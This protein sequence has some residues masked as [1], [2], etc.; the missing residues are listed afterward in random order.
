MRELPGVRKCAHQHTHKPLHTHTHT[1]TPHTLLTVPPP[2]ANGSSAVDVMLQ[3][4]NPAAAPQPHP[5]VAHNTQSRVNTVNPLDL[6]MGSSSNKTTTTTTTPVPAAAPTPPTGGGGSGAA[7]G[8]A[9]GN[10]ASSALLQQLLKG[11]SGA[12]PALPAPVVGPEPVSAE[13]VQQLLVRLSRNAQFVAA[14]TEE[15]N[16]LGLVKGAGNP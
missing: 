13:L 11:S 15:V 3:P 12:L 9:G 1:H 4:N 16:A 2:A 5:P 7:G 6:L 8:N 14:L 10:D